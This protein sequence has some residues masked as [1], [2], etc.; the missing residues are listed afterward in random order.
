M[1]Q[2]FNRHEHSQWSEIHLKE[3]QPV[4]EECLMVCEVDQCELCGYTEVPL[5]QGLSH[6]DHYIKRDIDPNLT[7]CWENMIAAVKDDKFGADWKDNHIKRNDYDK[8]MKC[9]RNVL[10]PIT[11]DFIDRFK[12]A[13]DG[14]MEPVDRN[15]QIAQNTID[16]FNLNEFSLKNRR[17][18]AMQAAR[19]MMNGGIDIDLIRQYLLPGGFI[20]AVEYEFS[21]N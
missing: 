12:F 17:K 15:D 20:S 6:I 8:K 9:Y 1:L 21:K 13:T 14:F 10:N 4:Y 7:F 18:E 5:N 3:N 16:V 2:S 19:D 11:S